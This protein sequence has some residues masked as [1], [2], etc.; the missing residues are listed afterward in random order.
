MQG[1]YYGNNSTIRLI[2]F[3]GEEETYHAWNYAS[4]EE[5]EMYGRRYNS[6]GYMFTDETGRPHYYDGQTDNYM[7]QNYQ[8]LFD[9]SFSN[10]LGMN[11]GLHYTKGDGYYQE[12]KDAK[13][14]TE[15]PFH[16]YPPREIL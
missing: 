5:M 8:L 15:F 9:H 7:Q 6:C 10:T 1:A 11:V 14:A 2:A 12:Y 13:Q 4:K 16:Q 3:A